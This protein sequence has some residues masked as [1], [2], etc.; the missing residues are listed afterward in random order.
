MEDV[1][2]LADKT[3]LS[4]TDDL[5]RQ[6]RKTTL[7][8]LLRLAEIDRRRL[9]GPL[10]YR[11]LWDFC[12]RR[13]GFSE[14]T[15]DR[16]IRVARL[17]RRFPD[18][19]PLLESRRVSMAT[20]SRAASILSAEN[21]DEVMGK[22][23]GKT[24]DEV[25]AV[26]ATYRTGS[27][28]PDR[29]TPVKV[30]SS[31]SEKPSAAASLSGN[32]LAQT[33]PVQPS[34][35]DC[36]LRSPS[37]DGQKFTTAGVEAA[38]AETKDEVCY[39]FVFGAD[40]AFMRKF[41]EVKALLSTKYPTSFTNAKVFQATMEVFLEKHSPA[42]RAERRAR[43]AAKKQDQKAGAKPARPSV[44]QR[45]AESRHIPA[46]VRDAVFTRDTGRCTYKGAGGVRCNSRH[47]VE[48]DHVMPYAHGGS[49]SLENLRLLCSLHNRL[50]AE[51]KLGSAVMQRYVQ[52]E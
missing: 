32:L 9:Y 4:T 11:S 5:V 12:R 6:Q 39:K 13:L 45:T 44:Q 16:H 18:I 20:L 15:T 30:A 34:N 40:E 10:G 1:T 37:S 7:A 24:Q 23:A 33:S 42:K 47:D 2:K 25:E 26:V 22:I 48:I 50:E 8:I 3:L 29:I 46:A 52:R 49:H 31:P 19:Y 17:L 21:K 38:S 41:N 35:G 27:P 43:R 14:S 36:Q 51:R 28:V